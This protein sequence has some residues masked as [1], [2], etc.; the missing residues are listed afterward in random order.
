MVNDYMHLV[1]AVSIRTPNFPMY[2]LQTLLQDK[3]ITSSVK[4]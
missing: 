3:I 2:H 4:E 1:I